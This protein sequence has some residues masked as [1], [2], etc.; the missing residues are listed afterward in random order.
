MK[1]SMPAS[2]GVDSSREYDLSSP[3]W[4]NYFRRVRK[5]VRFPRNYK[6]VSGLEEGSSE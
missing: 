3:L 2:S 4:D 1:R 5:N 6:E